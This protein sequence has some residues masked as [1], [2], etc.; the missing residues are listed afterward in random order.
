MIRVALGIK[1]TNEIRKQRTDFKFRIHPIDNLLTQ[2]YLNTEHETRR[3]HENVR[4]VTEE[5]ISTTDNQGGIYM[6]VH[7]ESKYRYIGQTQHFKKRKEQHWT[8]LGTIR[9]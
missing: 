7:P 8:E 2:L 6:L 3:N 1:K 4:L 9:D 5:D